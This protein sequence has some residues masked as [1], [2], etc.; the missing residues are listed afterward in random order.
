VKRIHLPAVG[1]LSEFFYNHPGAKPDFVKYQLASGES[2]LHSPRACV[3]A[4]T[5]AVA[6]RR[7]AAH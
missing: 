7:A 6:A 5:P 1:N 4:A 3:I 2:R